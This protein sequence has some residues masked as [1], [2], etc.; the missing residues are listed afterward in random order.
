[1]SPD[2]DSAKKYGDGI[3]K[4]AKR[5][6]KQRSLWAAL[7]VPSE[8]ACARRRPREYRRI[9]QVQDRAC[10]L[11]HK[12]SHFAAAREF[13]DND[14]NRSNRKAL[15]DKLAGL[16]ERCGKIVE[17]TTA[18]ARDISASVINNVILIGAL[19][20]RDHG[21]RRF[22]VIQGFT[23]PIERIKLS[24]LEL[25]EGNTEA[26]SMEPSGKDEIGEISGRPRHLP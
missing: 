26:A 9:H 20:F 18:S 16:S 15:N 24:I 4:S 11:A 12:R 7:V 19:S 3:L 10:S 1:M 2:W 25:S 21:R 17:E 23:R 14:A 22:L 6:T 5:S 13:G 8:A